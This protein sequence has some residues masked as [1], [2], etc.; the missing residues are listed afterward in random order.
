VR[1][2]G[3]TAQTG[4]IERILAM[5]LDKKAT[6]QVRLQKEAPHLVELDKKVGVS[7][8]KAGLATHTA[9]VALCLDISGSMA[10]LYSS[11]KVQAF[12]ERILTL[13]LRF[14]EDGSVDVFSFGVHA[15]IEEQITLD[16]YRD[17]TGRLRG[18]RPLEMGT[19][20]GQAIE[21]LRRHYLPA[22]G[23]R[24]APVADALPVYVMFVTDGQT[25]DESHT[26]KQIV[27]AAFDLLAVHGHRQIEEGREGQGRWLLREAVCVGLQLPRV[28]RHDGRPPR[29]QRE[30]LQRGRPGRAL[31]RSALRAHDGGIPWLG[32]ARPPEG[33]VALSGARLGARIGQGLLKLVLRPHEP[34][35]AI[36]KWAC[37]WPGTTPA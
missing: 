24:T 37:S 29:R 6:N 19:N 17:Y 32:S 4:S 14:D 22:P 8:Q 35:A 33:P 34:G 10:E 5:N 13:A 30:L 28:A 21:L 27:E 25:T 11:G 31:G 26:R 23:P 16:T 20:Y 15:Y 7:L 3:E 12:L 2:R 9:R 1:S 18:R 36:T